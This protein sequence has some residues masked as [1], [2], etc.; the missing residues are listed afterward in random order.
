[1]AQLLVRKIDRANWEEHLVHQETDTPGDAI[2]RCIRTEGNTL[3]LWQI[4]SIDKLEEAALAIIGCHKHPETFDVVAINYT[5][6]VDKGLTFISNEGTTRVNDLNN[7]HLEI[8]DI[9]YQKLGI[10]ASLIYDSLHH[11]MVRRYEIERQGEVLY[12]AIQ[13]GRLTMNSL[14]KSF[15]KLVDSISHRYHP[16]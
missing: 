3:S 14:S 1:M 10:L 13:A 12:K 11:D 2:T 16:N 7:T 9:T 5:D 8:I 4:E 15:R 6:L